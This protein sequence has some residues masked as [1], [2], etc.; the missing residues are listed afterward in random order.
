M[1]VGDVWLQKA[2]RGGPPTGGVQA[3]PPALSWTGHAQ[4]VPGPAEACHENP[5]G[6]TASLA[7]VSTIEH[8]FGNLS[9]S[10]RRDKCQRTHCVN[11]N[12]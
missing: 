2:P 7:L 1:S 8:C 4:P 5:T 12:K 3:P 9:G 6:R 11:K 10:S